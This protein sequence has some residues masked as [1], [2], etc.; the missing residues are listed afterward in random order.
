MS[1]IS[2]DRAVA[3]V[4]LKIQGVAMKKAD[5]V[6]NVAAKA[7]ISKS[8]AAAATDAVI[9][10]ITETL[11][12]GGS[13]SFIGFG[14]FTVSDRA[15]RTGRNPQTGAEVQIPAAK[16]PKFS[17]GAKLKAAVNGE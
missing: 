9:E 12:S 7:G 15:E 2:D 17:A 16:V 6:E 4:V 11:A 5:I 1:L 13:V 10:T 14:S 8:A 3:V